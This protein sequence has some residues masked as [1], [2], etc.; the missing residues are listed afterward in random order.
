MRQALL[1]TLLCLCGAAC[2]RQ[3]ESASIDTIVILYDKTD[4]LNQYA[5]TSDGTKKQLA[6]NHEETLAGANVKIA[7][8]TD[9]I[10]NPTFTASIPSEVEDESNALRRKKAIAQFNRSLDSIFTLAKQIKSGREH[11]AIFTPLSKALNELAIS[12]GRRQLV[13]LSDCQENSEL[14][15]VYKSNISELKKADKMAS[16]IPIDHSLTGVVIYLIHLPIS[17]ADDRRFNQISE[18]LKTYL[19]GKGA[20]VFIQTSLQ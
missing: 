5:I 14:F 8:L 15:N 12:K 18:M 9:L 16:V 19:E 3:E 17:T 1:L 2:S 20:T 10:Y 11:S 7:V 4:P 6:I 13:L